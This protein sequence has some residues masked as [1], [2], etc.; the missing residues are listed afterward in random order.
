MSASDLSASTKRELWGVTFFSLGTMKVTLDSFVL[1][2]RLLWI[3]GGRLPVL[4]LLKKSESTLSLAWPAR[5]AV[6]L[7][8]WTKTRLDR[9]VPLDAASGADM[10]VW[11]TFRRVCANAEIIPARFGRPVIGHLRLAAALVAKECGKFVEKL[12]G[13][14]RQENSERKVEELSFLKQPRDEQPILETSL[15]IPRRNELQVIP[16]GGRERVRHVYL[17]VAKMGGRLLGGLLLRS[18]CG[19]DPLER[20]RRDEHEFGKVVGVE[21]LR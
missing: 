19:S 7:V 4:S 2:G 3:C 18:V 8:I 11:F 17:H 6:K 20:Q 12:R 15:G 5:V 10:H 14:E 9:A 21:A 16:L 13:K 1:D